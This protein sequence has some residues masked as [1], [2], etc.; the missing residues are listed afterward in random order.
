[1]FL[2]TIALSAVIVGPVT[3]FAVAFA[4]SESAPFPFLVTTVT[5]VPS[6]TLFSGIVISPVF[7]SI[8][9]SGLFTVHLPLVPLVPT[10]VFG[11]SSS[12][13]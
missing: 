4:G 10:A 11:A 7:S 8:R 9:T 6:F 5:S 1:M 13:V 2:V 3:S 12:P